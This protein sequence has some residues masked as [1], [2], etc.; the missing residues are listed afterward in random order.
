MFE[1]QKVNNYYSLTLAMKIV[2]RESSPSDSET[3]KATSTVIS[4]PVFDSNGQIKA[5]YDTSGRKLNDTT[6]MKQGNVYILQDTGR[7]FKVVAK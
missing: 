4:L 1:P 7:Y 6:Q 2:T 5:V 3:I